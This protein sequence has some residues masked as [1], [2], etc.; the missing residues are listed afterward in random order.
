MPPNAISDHLYLKIFLGGMPLT[1]NGL[2]LVFERKLATPVGLLVIECM[3][4]MLCLPA[5]T[6]AT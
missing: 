1:P 5:F 2:V 3:A 4:E 6:V